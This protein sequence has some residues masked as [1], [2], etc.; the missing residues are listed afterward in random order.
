MHGEGQA[1]PATWGAWRSAVPH[2]CLYSFLTPSPHPV[3]LPLCLPV[4]CHP[5]EM[6]EIIL[7][8]QKMQV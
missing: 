6:R 2:L 7:S 1:Q 5:G 4:T 3:R 8:I